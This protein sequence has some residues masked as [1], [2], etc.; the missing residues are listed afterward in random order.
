MLSRTV[1]YKH[2]KQGLGYEVIASF[3]Q[4]DE[5]SIKAVLFINK[6]IEEVSDCILKPAS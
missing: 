2:N 4:A 3:E 6:N 1:V 5:K